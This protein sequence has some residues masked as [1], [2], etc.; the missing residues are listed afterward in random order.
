[1]VKVQ[2]A[3]LRSQS[4]W[5][6]YGLATKK[7]SHFLLP[8]APLTFFPDDARNFDYGT[9][10][11]AG[12]SRCPGLKPSVENRRACNSVRNERFAAYHRHDGEYENERHN[13]ANASKLRYGKVSCFAPPAELLCSASQR[14]TIVFFSP[15]RTMYSIQR[16]GCVVCIPL[17][18]RRMGALVL[19]KTCMYAHDFRFWG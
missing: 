6:W 3:A 17:H 10:H 11:R 8:F 15:T 9:A 13:N 16:V 2:R 19:C 5:L 7:C 14:P 1:M 18:K 12:P 4:G